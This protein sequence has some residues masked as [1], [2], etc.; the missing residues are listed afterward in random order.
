MKQNHNNKVW[1][2]TSNSRKLNS[3]MCAKLW[4]KE[5][6]LYYKTLR[7]ASSFILSLTC[8]QKCYAYLI[9]AFCR[10]FTKLIF[11]SGE[12]SLNYIFHGNKEGDFI[13]KKFF[14]FEFLIMN[15]MTTLALFDKLCFKWFWIF[16]YKNNFTMIHILLFYHFEE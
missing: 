13:M 14:L 15:T 11:N 10:F 5:K 6:L 8:K 12:I 7:M 16:Y 2:Q 4:T 3:E 1:Y 9:Y